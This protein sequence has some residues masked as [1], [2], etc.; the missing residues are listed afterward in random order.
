MWQS[1]AGWFAAGMGVYAVL[2]VV[3]AV[4]FVVRGVGKIDP[5][6]Q[7]GT[8]GFRVLIFPGSVALWP[9]LLLRWARNSPMP[10]E[11]NSH[12]QCAQKHLEAQS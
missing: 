11:Q 6:A 1:I 4:P 5:V 12:R 3:F 7:N 10:A 8:W 9:I 2:G